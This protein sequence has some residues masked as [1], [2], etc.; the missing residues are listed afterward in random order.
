MRNMAAPM[1]AKPDFFADQ[2]KPVLEP[3]RTPFPVTIGRHRALHGG[4]LV[5]NPH[6]EF[7]WRTAIEEAARVENYEAIASL[8]ETMDVVAELLPSEHGRRSP[9]AH[10]VPVCNVGASLR[11]PVGRVVPYYFAN[12]V[13]CGRSGCA[14]GYAVPPARSV[15]RVD[16]LELALGL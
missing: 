5:P 16:Q 12:V 1:L 13:T 6:G 11:D 8:I 2:R 4:L 14:G 15:P 10:L 7:D 3:R 9:R